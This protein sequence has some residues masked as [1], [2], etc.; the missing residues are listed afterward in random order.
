MKIFVNPVA[1]QPS[2]LSSTNIQ[3]TRKLFDLT[4]VDLIN[5]SNGDI[6]VY[7]ASTQKIISSNTFNISII[8]GG[9]F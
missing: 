4:D 5:I 1:G 2:I 8:D 9:T 3:T 6:L 7:D